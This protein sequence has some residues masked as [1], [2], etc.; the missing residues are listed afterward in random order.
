[1]LMAQGM[2][3]GGVKE[4][5]MDQAARLI[6]MEIYTQVNITKDNNMEM[7]LFVGQ[8]EVNMWVDSTLARL[9]AKVAITGQT[10]ETSKANGVTIKQ[11]VTVHLYGQM[12]RDMSVTQ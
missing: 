10:V 3:G 2:M 4:K 5:D 12:E 11:M 1:M 8:M 9:K 6:L 7:V